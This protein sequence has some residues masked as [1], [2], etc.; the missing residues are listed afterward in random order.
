[1]KATED[2]VSLNLHIDTDLLDTK[3]RLGILNRPL[4]EYFDSTHGLSYMAV[5]MR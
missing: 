2:C 3:F 5:P 4:N 1:M